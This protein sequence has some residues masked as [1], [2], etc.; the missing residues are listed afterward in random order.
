MS[1]VLRTSL[2]E[3][4]AVLGRPDPSPATLDVVLSGV[5]LPGGP[6]EV[7]KPRNW[8]TLHD[9]ESLAARPTPFWALVWPSGHALGRAVACAELDGSRVLELGCGLGV[10]SLAAARRGAEVLATDG[11][12]EAVAF[13][14]HSFALN[15]LRGDVALVDWREAGALE[16]AGDRWD[17]VLASDVLYQR[18]GVE[19]LLRLLPR[20]LAPDGEV[21]V[22]DPG[23]A[24][25]EDFLQLA[26]R[27]WRRESERDGEDDRVRLH[28]LRRR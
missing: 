11:T 10:P 3:Q 14:A 17:L 27:E 22:A 16:Q 2:L 18:A 5:A 21:W 6:L 12:P 26:M 1:E 4:L 20:V 13:T 28:R 9:D 24:G 23:R 15:D 25:A 19:A 7:L 8:S